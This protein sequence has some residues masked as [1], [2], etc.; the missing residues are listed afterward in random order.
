M[1]ATIN[2]VQ[3]GYD[4]FGQGPAVLFVHDYPLNR[5]MWQPQVDPLVQA[6]FRVILVDLRGFGESTLES[7]RL[8]I[9]TYS[10]DII[11]LLNYLGIGRAVICGLSLGGFVLFDLMENYPHRVAGACLATS[12]PVADD[13]QERARRAELIA[14]LHKGQFDQVKDELFGM[15]FAGQEDTLSPAILETVRN[16]I[17]GLKAKTLAVAL[18]AIGQRKDYTFLLKSLKIPTLLLG[19]E[20]DPITHHTH[21]DIMAQQLPNCYNAVKLS[22]GH[23]ANM[24]KPDEFN[25]HILDFLRNLVPQ[26]KEQVSIALS[27]AI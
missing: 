1:Q 10:A 20:F 5:K 26:K 13:I 21:T 9:E 24:E 3:I 17:Q 4:D 14:A 2:G 19:A 6:G 25:N 8:D 11:G 23:L 27:S 18:H 16:L 15:L 7:D 22:S 12:R